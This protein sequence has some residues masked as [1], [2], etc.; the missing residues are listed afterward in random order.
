MGENPWA[1]FLA[2]RQERKTLPPLELGGETYLFPSSPPAIIWFEI[3]EWQRKHN[4]PMPDEIAATKVL[5]EMIGQDRFESLCRELTLEEMGE[6]IV[7]LFQAWGWS[8]EEE[9]TPPNRQARRASA[10]ASGKGSAR[11]KRTSKR[12][13]ASS[14]KSSG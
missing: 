5:P 9:E 14:S 3:T 4:Q 12:T 8:T 13:T 10:K 7:D 6:F 2:K 11:S 1:S